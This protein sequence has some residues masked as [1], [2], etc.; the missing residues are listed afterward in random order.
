[1]LKNNEKILVS[2]FAIDNDC[3]NL[4]V[5]LYIEPVLGLN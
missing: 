2:P 4:L 3:I 5:E 1:M